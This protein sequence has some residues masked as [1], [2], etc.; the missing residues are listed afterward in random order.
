[1]STKG[2]RREKKRRKKQHGMKVDGSGNRLLARI[3]QDKA[4]EAK[5]A[6]RLRQ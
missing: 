3:V 1:M 2:E 5:S 4:E 6:K